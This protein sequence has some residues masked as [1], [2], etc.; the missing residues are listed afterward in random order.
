MRIRPCNLIIDHPEEGLT[1]I[2]A[3][4][5]IGL[6]GPEVHHVSLHYGHNV[7]MGVN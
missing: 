3:T 7:V 4:R 1:L 2:D 6:S 5:R